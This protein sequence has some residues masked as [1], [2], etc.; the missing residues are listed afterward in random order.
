MFHYC[1]DYCPDT[2]T[3]VMRED[4]SRNPREFEDEMAGAMAIL[5]AFTG[6]GAGVAIVLDG[7]ETLIWLV[8]ARKVGIRHLLIDPSLPGATWGRAM[9]DFRPSMAIARHQQQV[10]DTG[11]RE[12][13]PADLWSNIDWFFADNSSSRSVPTDAR[14]LLVA[15]D[16]VPTLLCDAPSGAVRCLSVRSRVSKPSQSRWLFANGLWHWPSLQRLLF[17]LGNGSTIVVLDKFNAKQAVASLAKYDIT[18]AFWAAWSLPAFA[19]QLAG[20]NRGA[21]AERTRPTLSS[22]QQLEIV[23]APVCPAALALI[24]PIL[25]LPYQRTYQVEPSICLLYTS[26]AADE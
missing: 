12:Y 6:A 16:K 19:Q 26:D 15:A 8:A 7:Y 18:N 11:V 14:G 21:I 3:A 5:L 4:I 22:F 23:G 20:D 24:E 9:S 13:V 17:E 10:W 1:L 2:A 25:P